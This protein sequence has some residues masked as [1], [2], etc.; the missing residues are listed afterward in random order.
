MGIGRSRV[1]P[2]TFNAHESSDGNVALSTTA[3]PGF[4]VDDPVS[5]ALPGIGKIAV[6]EVVATNEVVIVG[7]IGSSIEDGLHMLLVPASEE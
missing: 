2:I 5:N 1:G 7:C 6:R 3:P 4:S